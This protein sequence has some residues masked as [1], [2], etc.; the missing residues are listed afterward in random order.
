MINSKMILQLF[1]NSNL[2][3]VCRFCLTPPY[4][5][6]LFCY[7]SFNSKIIFFIN[8]IIID[9]LFFNFILFNISAEASLLT[10]FLSSF[11]DYFFHIHKKTKERMNISQK[12]NAINYSL[13]T[14]FFD[15]YSLSNFFIT[16]SLFL[17]TRIF[18][19]KKRF[20]A[21]FVKLLK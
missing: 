8:S 3:T 1:K 18:G 5:C 21:S 2:W 19:S 10:R 17:F 13:Y 7:L 11:A 14:N 16:P 20:F 6:F 9:Y 4:V 15:Y 12:L